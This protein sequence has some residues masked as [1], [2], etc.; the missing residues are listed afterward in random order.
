MIKGYT[1]KS[2]RP[3]MAVLPPTYRGMLISGPSLTFTDAHTYLSL[4][5]QSKNSTT[6]VNC[7]STIIQQQ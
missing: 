4:D 5:L 3:L 1:G 2:I 7:I 6:F